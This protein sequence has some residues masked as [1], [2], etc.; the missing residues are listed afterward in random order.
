MATCFTINQSALK[1]SS[2]IVIQNTEETA[3][4]FIGNKMANNITNCLT[5]S[6]Q[7]ITETVENKRQNLAKDI[8]L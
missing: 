2:E 7:N 6:S 4:N 5:T 1:I 3:S 8:Y